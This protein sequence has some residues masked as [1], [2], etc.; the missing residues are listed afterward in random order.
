[1]R[2]DEKKAL[3]DRAQKA[4]DQQQL[5]TVRLCYRAYLFNPQGQMV[6]EIGPTFSCTI[7]DTKNCPS[8][9]ICKIDKCVGSVSGGDTIYLLCDKVSREDIDVIFEEEN[10]RQTIWSAKG[11]F[12]PSEVHHQVS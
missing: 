8:L 4:C 2:N 1:M 10:E 3:K 5:T 9:K 6:Q 7:T 12:Q 11:D